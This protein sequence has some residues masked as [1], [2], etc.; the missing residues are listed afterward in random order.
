MAGAFFVGIVV[1]LRTTE[2]AAQEKFE[3]EKLRTYVGIGVNTA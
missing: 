1:S 3:E 2:T